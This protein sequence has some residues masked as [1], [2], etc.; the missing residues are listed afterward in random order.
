MIMY[1]SGVAKIIWLFTASPLP[2]V[3]RRDQQPSCPPPTALDTLV[4]EV[5]RDSSVT[6]PPGAVASPGGQVTIRV[7]PTPF[8]P[9]VRLYRFEPRQGRLGRLYRAGV[10][11]KSAYRVAGWTCSNLGDWIRAL[12]AVPL[13]SRRAVWKRLL[14]LGSAV[15]PIGNSTK[16]YDPNGLTGLAKSQLVGD[17]SSITGAT[18]PALN[19]D[20]ANGWRGTVLIAF[21]D[22]EHRGSELV[23]WEFAFDPQGSVVSL[24]Q[25]P[26]VAP[27]SDSARV[28]V[29]G[30]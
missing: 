25:Y 19:G 24:R 3:G 29:G 27:Q 21:Y 26:V 28:I 14:A 22:G 17:L 13:P 30:A 7:Q 23:K 2:V 11:D 5:A 6:F 10:I 12:P 15:N 8:G 4:A 18:G 16:L 9:S 20:P 1:S